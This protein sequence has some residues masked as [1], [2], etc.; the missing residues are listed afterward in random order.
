MAPSKQTTGS[1][2]KV[3]WNGP[4]VLL[5]NRRVMLGRGQCQ[6]EHRHFQRINRTDASALSAAS[7]YGLASEKRARRTNCPIVLRA[8]DP[9][10]PPARRR[11]IL[12][13]A[14]G[15]RRSP[16]AAVLAPGQAKPFGWTA[17][18]PPALTGP[19]RDGCETSSGVLELRSERKNARGVGRTKEWTQLPSTISSSHHAL[20]TK[21]NF[22]P[23]VSRARLRA[24]QDA[25]EPVIIIAWNW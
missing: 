5:P 6:T 18:T 8:R 23:N 15:P 12:D 20:T 13:Q 22:A 19:A 4:A 21:R 24:D 1:S 9:T 10:A 17:K 2:P 11:P 16:Y 7:L 25:P 14:R 3:Q